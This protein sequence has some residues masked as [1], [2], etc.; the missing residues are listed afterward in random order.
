MSCT[1]L[2]DL[3]RVKPYTHKGSV[4]R[5]LALSI[6]TYWSKIQLLP[7]RLHLH[8]IINQWAEVIPLRDLPLHWSLIPGHTKTEKL[9]EANN[10]VSSQFRTSFKI[11]QISN[12]TRDQHPVKTTQ[13]AWCDTGSNPS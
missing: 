11:S 7:G 10:P 13:G 12:V 3:G 8:W 2:Q 9:R 4:G 5:Y 6:V 1:T